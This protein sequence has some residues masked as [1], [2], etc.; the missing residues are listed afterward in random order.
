MAKCFVVAVIIIVNVS[1]KSTTER[2]KIKPQYSIVTLFSKNHLCEAIHSCRTYAHVSEIKNG[3]VAVIGL[4]ASDVSEDNLAIY[5]KNCPFV[6]LRPFTVSGYPDFFKN[7]KNY[8]FKFPTV[9]KVLSEFKTIFYVDASIQLKSDANDTLTDLFNS[10]WAE[11]APQ[12]IR[13]FS[14]SSHLNFPVTHSNMY[15]FFN[16]TETQTKETYQLQSGIYMLN[17][18]PAGWEI[19]NKMIQCSLEPKCMAPNRAKVNCNIQFVLKNNRVVCHRFDQS[20]LNMR[21]NPKKAVLLIVVVGVMAV[22]NLVIKS[23]VASVNSQNV[24][25]LLDSDFTNF[26]I[27]VLFQS[28]ESENVL[29]DS[30]NLTLTDVTG[31]VD[32]HSTFSTMPYSMGQEN[33]SGVPLVLEWNYIGCRSL[34]HDR[35]GLEKHCKY[36][37]TYT[38][39][40][41]LLE[42]AAVT[43]YHMG[44]NDNIPSRSMNAS[45]VKVFLNLES[46]SHRPQFL[47][48]PARFFD[49]SITYRQDSTIP[50][51]Y[52]SF[53]PLDGAND[54]DRWTDAEV[55]AAIRAKEKPA[56]W[57]VS[58]CNTYSAREM[59]VSTL[60]QHI[61]VTQ[62]GG[63]NQV[64]CPRFDDCEKSYI[65]N[66]YFYIAFESAV[67]IDYITEKFFRMRQLIV[68]IV[69]DK[70]VFRGI[71]KTL[72]NYTIVASD[73]ESQ[74][75]L[76]EYLQHL[77]DHP[78]E[79]RKYFDWTKLYKKSEQPSFNTNTA[80]KV[81]EIANQVQTGT[82]KKTKLNIHEWWGKNSCYG[83]VG[84]DLISRSEL[85]N[86]LKD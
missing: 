73:F 33:V 44:A 31:D 74:K 4:Y 6:Q 1:L 54:T 62:I 28:V 18:S 5:S 65:R 85:S 81:C 70:R 8:R 50:V 2:G 17:N 69:L 55:E 72:L 43:V 36:T 61:N 26:Q 41:S 15:D 75:Q 80:C 22:I 56:L 49:V 76:A 82:Y 34:F 35:A 37:C 9:A 30:E 60:K 14:N 10:M 77:I 12:G 51:Y 48:L 19:M 86:K 39:N 45:S 24:K 53:V 66:H 63:C 64:E 47:K 11:F 59:Y 67:C 38:A 7:L 52:D 71:H 23:S 21:M 16:V 68:P 58:H 27:G 79:Y 25:S 78:D 32:A 20:A 13:L 42:N 84:K 57:M 83:P 3:N 46:P 40:H 29:S